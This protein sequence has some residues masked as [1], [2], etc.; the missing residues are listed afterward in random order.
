VENVE[1]CFEIK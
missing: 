1:G